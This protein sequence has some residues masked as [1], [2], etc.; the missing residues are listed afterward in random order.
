VGSTVRYVTRT[1]NPGWGPIGAFRATAA[2]TPVAALPVWYRDT[3]GVCQAV[4]AWTGD[5]IALEAVTPPT[6]RPGPLSFA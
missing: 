3:S 2:V 6:D 4:A 5:L 1:L